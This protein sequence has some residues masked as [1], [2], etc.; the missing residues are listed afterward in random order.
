MTEGYEW[1]HDIK[2]GDLVVV[3]DG[4][5]HG[6]PAK[7]VRT[8]P[9]QVIVVRR[10]SS[11]EERYRKETGREIGQASS[12]HRSWLVRMTPGAEYGFAVR[13]TASKVRGLV[14]HAAEGKY[15]LE[16]WQQI[17][18]LLDEEK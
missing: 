15:P 7:V 1:R 12:W 14:M 4:T 3:R 9:T 2:V 6:H 16:V 13:A 18:A 5:R 17:L 10:G 8:T 11:V